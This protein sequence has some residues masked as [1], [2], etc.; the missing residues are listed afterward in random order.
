MRLEDRILKFAVPVGE[1]GC[2]IWT[3]YLN[4]DGYGWMNVRGN[5]R[6]AHRVSKMVF[7]GP[8]DLL[9]TSDRQVLHHCDVRSCVNPDHLY[10]GTPADNN[11]DA[12]RRGRARWVKPPT[13]RGPA[14]GNAKLTEQAVHEI[15][16]TRRATGKANRW[17]GGITLLSF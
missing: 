4:K 2:W 3:G 8:T 10:L 15:L 12:R 14:N 16:E 5:Y 13:L 9:E 11:R 17:R 7:H 6:G 1:S